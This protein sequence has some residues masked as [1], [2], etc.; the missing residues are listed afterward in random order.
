MQHSLYLHSPLLYIRKL[1]EGEDNRLSTMVQNL[2]LTGGRHLTS[3]V[4]V[5]ASASA[6]DSSDTAATS[7][8]DGPP[9]A[10]TSSKTEKSAGAARVE[11]ASSDTQTDGDVE[12]QA[13][14]TSERKTVLIR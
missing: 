13:T 2:S 1:I 4:S 11:V 9:S 10:T 6:S 3:S 14:E 12:E 8:L 5:H 7:K